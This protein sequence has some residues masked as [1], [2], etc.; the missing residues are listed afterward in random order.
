MAD[1]R[2]RHLG[3]RSDTLAGDGEDEDP[4]ERGG[5]DDAYGQGDEPQR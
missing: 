4:D 5:A 3:Q 2:D 1:R